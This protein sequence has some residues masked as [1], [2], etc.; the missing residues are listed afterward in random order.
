MTT[1][2]AQDITNVIARDDLKLATVLSASAFFSKT[3]VAL[4]FVSQLAAM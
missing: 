3:R 4:L 1:L 2:A